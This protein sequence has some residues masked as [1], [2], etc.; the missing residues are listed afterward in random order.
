MPT[1]KNISSSELKNRLLEVH[2]SLESRKRTEVWINA[3]F[4]ILIWVI[5]LILIEQQA[6]LSPLSKISFLVLMIGLSVF[7]V[8]IGMKK[9]AKTPFME[10]YRN[11]SND[12]GIPELTYALDLEKNTAGNPKLVEAAIFKN[13]ELVDPSLFNAK[14]NDY[15]TSHPITARLKTKRLYSGALLILS[16]ITAFSFSEAGLRLSQFWVPFHKPNPYL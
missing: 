8:F 9:L 1:S 13:L 10:F 15:L 3:A 7:A 12:S 6:Y 2:Q 16:V 5:S 11:F 4:M 14:L